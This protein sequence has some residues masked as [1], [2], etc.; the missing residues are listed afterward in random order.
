M[1][2]LNKVSVAVKGMIKTINYPVVWKPSLYMFLSLALSIS[3][4]EGQF[5]WYTNK[6]PPNPGFSQVVVL[7]LTCLMLL[8]IIIAVTQRN[9]TIDLHHNVL[10]LMS[11]TIWIII[12]YMAKKQL[13]CWMNVP[14]N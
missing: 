8:L 5:Y 7:F 1:Q 13:Y 11:Y 4:H 14:E 2:V 6:T 10:A 12:A 9:G 3:T